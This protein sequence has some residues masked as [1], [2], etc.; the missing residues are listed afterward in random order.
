M[1]KFRTE[2]DKPDFQTCYFFNLANDEQAYNEFV[3]KQ[4]NESDSN[5]RIQFKII[6]VKSKANRE[7]N[8]DA[9]EELRVLTKNNS[10]TT[11]GSKKK[12]ARTI[13]D[14]V[15]KFVEKYNVGHG[16][17]SIAKPKFLLGR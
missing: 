14:T 9:T 15:T 10:T 17:R 6:H 12:R 11:I 2:A 16:K 7:E 5:D 3:S 1:R 13:F 8:F 4:I